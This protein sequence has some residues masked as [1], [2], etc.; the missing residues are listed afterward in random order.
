MRLMSTVHI[1]PTAAQVELFKT[2]IKTLVDQLTSNVI[3]GIVAK[4]A[5]RPSM[6]RVITTKLAEVTRAHPI[7][8]I[9]AAA[10]AGFL[11]VRLIRR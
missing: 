1:D 6:F 10:G 11:V 3:D 5:P 4:V 9:A 7:A 8:A 2:T